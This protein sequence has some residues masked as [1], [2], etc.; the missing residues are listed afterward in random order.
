C[1][2]GS[3]LSIPIDEAAII[4]FFPNV[5]SYGFW[6]SIAI[7]KMELSA[8]RQPGSEHSLVWANNVFL[9]AV[10]L[11]DSNGVHVSMLEIR[12]QRAIQIQDHVMLMILRNFGG[13]NAPG[14]QRGGVHRHFIDFFGTNLVRVCK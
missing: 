5:D 10:D 1:P 9:L 13:A 8:H 6:L 11:F 12:C 4:P 3:G 7:K 14:F 2:D